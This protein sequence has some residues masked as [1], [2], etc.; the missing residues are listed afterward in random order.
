MKSM[1]PMLEGL[2]LSTEFNQCLIFL[3][4]RNTQPL[5]IELSTASFLDYMK[6]T[7][8]EINIFLNTPMAI[9]EILKISQ[10]T[11]ITHKS[12]NL[13]PFKWQ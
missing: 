5:Q 12:C 4:Y 9:L 10:D 3:Q 11:H 8:L 1:R 7:F 6:D 13:M 2:I